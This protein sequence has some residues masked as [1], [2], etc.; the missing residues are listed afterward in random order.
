MTKP[1]KVLLFVEAVVCFGPAALFLPI[2]VMMVPLQIFVLFRTSEPWEGPLWL[3]GMVTGGLAGMIALCFVLAKLWDN[4]RIER[5]RLVLL[6]TAMGVA[7]L[8]S[9]AGGVPDSPV[10]A[11]VLGLPLLATAHIL[12]LARDLLCHCSLGSDSDA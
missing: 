9:Y 2:G 12:F 10:G 1:F 5:P 6:G 4:S 11:V 7:A 3:I 8:V